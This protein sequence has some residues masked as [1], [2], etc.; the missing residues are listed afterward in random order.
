MSLAMIQSAP[1]APPRRLR[2]LAI[3][4]GSGIALIVVGEGIWVSLIAAYSRHPTP[5]PWFVPAMALVLALAAAWMK[6]GTWPAFG[7]AARR[8]GVRLN[9]VPLQTFLLALV[10]G[11]STFFAGA[12]AYV[13][14]RMT[15]GLG[16]EVPMTIP[17]GPKTAIIA[18]LAMA[19]IVAGVLE[20]VSVRGFIQGRLEKSFGVVPAILVSGVVWALFHTNHS[21]F[22]TTPF[23]VAVWFGIFLVVSAMLGTVAHVTNSVLPGIVIHAG[24]DSTYFISAG[25][26]QPKIA[27]LAYLESLASPQTFLIAGAGLAVVALVSWI[28]LFRSVRAAR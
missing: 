11:W 8:E 28:A 16:G 2:E 26:L 9:A 10:A 21:Y 19:A 3:A 6:W 25:L 18:G 7:A 12:G 15:S 23:D 1:A 22:Q 17:P 20:E 24:F 4:I 13:A 5:F 14:Y 27:P